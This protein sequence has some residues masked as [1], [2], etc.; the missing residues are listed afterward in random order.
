M[1]DACTE[2]QLVEQPAIG[3]FAELG[4]QHRQA[5]DLLLPRVLS[6]RLLCAAKQGYPEVCYLNANG[7]C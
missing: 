7:C 2:D 1:A 3:L 4:W 6:G 5:R